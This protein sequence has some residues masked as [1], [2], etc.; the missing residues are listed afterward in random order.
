MAATTKKTIRV[1][2]VHQFATHIAC[3]SATNSEIVV[4]LMKEGKVLG[5]LDIDSPLLNRFNEQDEKNLKRVVEIL[6][7]HIESV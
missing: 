1:D 3:D 5:V 7:P 4:P 2:D 6:L